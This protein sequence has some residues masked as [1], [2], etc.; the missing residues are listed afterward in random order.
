M[1]YGEDGKIL[2]YESIRKPYFQEELNILYVAITRAKRWLRLSADVAK[3]LADLDATVRKGDA[4]RWK[5]FEDELRFNQEFEVS[6]ET[7]PF[8][9]GPPHN[10]LA[11]PDSLTVEEAQR[12]IGEALLRWHP[13]KF[14]ALLG[15]RVE[16]DQQKPGGRLREKL[17][18]V[19]RELLEMR[20]SYSLGG[21]A[22]RSETHCLVCFEEE[23]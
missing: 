1:P 11:L 9:K 14:L 22:A 19:T 2:P 20:K 3:L 8:P 15:D 21:E 23:T 13:D 16:R 6:A 7:V 5:L 4:A 18:E 17:G 10:I 12:I